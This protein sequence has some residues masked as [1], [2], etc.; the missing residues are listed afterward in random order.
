MLRLDFHLKDVCEYGENGVWLVE[1]CEEEV[2][3]QHVPADAPLTVNRSEILSAAK[4][5]LSSFENPH[6]QIC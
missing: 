6:C 2:Q 3:S 1:G 5:A 4:I